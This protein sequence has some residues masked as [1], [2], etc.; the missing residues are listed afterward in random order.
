MIEIVDAKY[1]QM[2]ISRCVQTDYGYVGCSANVLDILNPLC[3]RYR[4]CNVSVTESTFSAVRPCPWFETS[5]LD[6]SFQCIP[7]ESFS[8]SS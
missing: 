2:E 6:V 5:Y 8:L 4:T 7:G 3:S 1:G